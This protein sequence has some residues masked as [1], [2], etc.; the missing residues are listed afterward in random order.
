[1]NKHGYKNGYELILPRDLFIQS[2]LL[3]CLGRL[4]LLIHDCCLPQIVSQ[5][6]EETT[7]R[8][9]I[10]LSPDNT[11]YCTNYEV[12]VGAIP[13]DLYI[14][15]GCRSAYPLLVVA[16][17]ASDPDPRYVF[18]DEGNFTQEFLALIKE[19]ETKNGLFE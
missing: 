4:S 19:L 2:K 1:M 5:E 15:Y 16:Y 9:L 13:L 8:F 12:Y 18:D 14:N 11:V 10:E 7:N 3:K 17:V 6:L